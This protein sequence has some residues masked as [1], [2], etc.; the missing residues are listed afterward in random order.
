[1]STNIKIAAVG[2]ILMIGKLIQAAKC[3]NE[4][5][6]DFN[7]MFEHVRP[8]LQE[9][10]LTIGNLEIPLAGRE[11]HYTHK[12]TKTGFTMFNCPDE[13]ASTLKASGFDVLCT[14]NNHALDRGYA[15]LQRT[16]EILD[17]HGIA[18]TGTYT[19]AED[20]AN[21]LIL[22]VKGIKIGILAYSKSTN[23]LPIPKDKTWC[24]DLLDPAKIVNDIEHVKKQTDLL[25][26]CPHFGQEY[27]HMPTT[28]QRKL[29]QL[30]LRHGADIILG[31]H[32]HVIQPMV[33]TRQKQVAVYSLGNFVSTTLNRNPYTRNGMILHIEVT[34]QDCGAITM[35]G[36]TSIPT[37]ILR[38]PQENAALYRILPAASYTD[39]TIS[40]ARLTLTSNERRA[41]MKAQK[42]TLHLL[43]QRISKINP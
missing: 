16:L 28:K 29:V 22:H 24:I 23:K 26:V 30:M 21:P 5:R 2:D 32:P 14:A 7:P 27:R 10:D 9:A 34:K 39:A 17:Q 18:H 43:S 40:N 8:Y 1:M 15:G 12:N 13:L 6:Y 33:I 19:S 25:I 31:S 35:S 37:W 41:L 38:R 20:A 42:H 4:D 3:S 36:V 11:N